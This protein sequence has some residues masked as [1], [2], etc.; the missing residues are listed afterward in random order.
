MKGKSRATSE[1]IPEASVSRPRPFLRAQSDQ[2]TPRPSLEYFRPFASRD[3]TFIKKR[4]ASNQIHLYQRPRFFFRRAFY[5]G[6]REGLPLHALTVHRR[7]RR[8]H[9]T[10]YNY[11]NSA[12]SIATYER[13]TY[14]NALIWSAHMLKWPAHPIITLTKS[15]QG[16]SWAIAVADPHRHFI[17]SDFYEWRLTHLQ[18][19]ACEQLNIERGGWQL[20]R[21]DRIMYSGDESTS[22]VIQRQPEVVAIAGWPRPP[23]GGR[24]LPTWTAA[25]EPNRLFTLR[26]QGRGATGELGDGWEVLAIVTWLGLWHRRH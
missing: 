8:P 10:L 6:L 16:S 25:S 3:P 23:A 9:I 19:E 21:K 14:H 11:L 22:K 7:Y 20:L 1:G 17:Y 26:F 2:P 5:L 15:P 24:M 18:E 4:F 12:Q 13:L